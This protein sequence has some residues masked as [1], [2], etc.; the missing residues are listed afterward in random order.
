V[1]V[2][3]ADKPQ[4][5][6][7]QVNKR[8]RSFRI[9][10]GMRYAAGLSQAG[11]LRA[12]VVPDKEIENAVVSLS[13]QLRAYSPRVEPASDE[14]GLFWLDASGLGR[15][16]GS[17]G[18]WAGRIQS[19]LNQNGFRVTV[20]VGFTRFG[21]YA[22][23]KA[24]EGIVVLRK[25]E[26]ERS[27]ARRV[28]LDRLA[29]EPATRDTLVKLGIKTVGQFIH[30]PPEGILKRFGQAA[31]RLHRLAS[32]ELN[33]P[34]QSERPEP[35]AVQ[36][37]TLDHPESDMERLMVV[38]KGLLGSLL[39]NLRKRGHALDGVNVILR[40]ERIGKHMEYIRPA[41]RTLDSRQLLDLIRLRLQVARKLPDGVVEVILEGHSVEEKHK[42]Y[43]LFGSPPKRDLA[44]ANRALARVRAEFGDEAVL[45]A[46]LRAGHLPE[47]RFTWEALETLGEP[48]ARN[49]DTG[50]LIR[51]IY[52]RPVALGQQPQEAQ[53]GWMLFGFEQGPVVNMSGAY[54]VSGG[55]W[56]RMVH[57][58]YYF[59]ETQKGGIFWVYYDRIRRRWFLHGR[60]E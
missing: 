14:P 46:R 41:E 5:E 38:I 21:T 51:R 50:R 57:R 56:R 29:L 22:L 15:L 36:E 34:L 7:L 9:L 11:I 27:A 17:P 53:D 25:P 16:Y 58:E 32:G 30:L 2:V 4:G 48:K 33:M 55:W 1:A 45:Q 24:K 39:Q 49:V 47:G 35:A 13:K 28:T 19:R 6:I 20:V 10:P 18:K 43:R 42:Q 23:A 54:I 31:H 8:A 12:A 52:D 26:E 59:L 60:V 37:L 44:A 40:F 3:D